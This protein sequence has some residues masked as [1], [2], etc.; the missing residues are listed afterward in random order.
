MFEADFSEFIAFADNF[1]NKAHRIEFIEQGM[2]DLGNNLLTLSIDGAPRDT[3]TL[4]LGFKFNGVSRMG[5]SYEAKVIN[6]VHYALFVEKGHRTRG[7][8]RWV[9][10]VFMCEKALHQTA[11]D[12]NSIIGERYIQF[13]NTLGFD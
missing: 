4:K 1:S 11:G 6:N 7:G 3:G 13:I 8:K 5:S 9:P 2:N 10:G 12:M